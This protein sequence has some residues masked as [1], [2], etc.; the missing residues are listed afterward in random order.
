MLA[1]GRPFRD[2]LWHKEF[3]VDAGKFIGQ[4]G[5]VQVR[6][7]NTMLQSK[8]RFD[9]PQSSGGRLGMAEIRLHRCERTRAFDAVYLGQAGVFD[10]VT[11]QVPVPCASTMPTLRASTPAAAKA[12]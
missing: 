7:N 3:G 2:L 12:A 10:G 5:E 11:D 9:Q 4:T 6:W 1:V 8:H